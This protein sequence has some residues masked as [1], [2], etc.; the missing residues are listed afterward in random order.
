MLENPELQP[1]VPPPTLPDPNAVIVASMIQTLASAITEPEKIKATADI[2][3]TKMFIGLGRMSIMIA[4]GLIAAFLIAAL[5]ALACGEKGLVSQVISGGFGFL[6]GI[7]FS[8]FL[9]Q[10]Q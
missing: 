2:E 5:I 7:G 10:K 1:V 3:K 8:R 6:A 9:P 4:A